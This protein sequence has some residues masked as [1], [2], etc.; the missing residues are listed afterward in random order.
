M[1][2]VAG[3]QAHEWLSVLERLLALF[4]HTSTRGLVY[5][6]CVTSSVVP[7][8]IGVVTFAALDGPGYYAHLEK[9]AFEETRVILRFYAY[10]FAIAVVQTVSFLL[11]V[12]SM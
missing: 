4:T 8:V 10:F 2:R 6:S 3:K 5:I 12:S 11:F 9:W 1:S 7:A